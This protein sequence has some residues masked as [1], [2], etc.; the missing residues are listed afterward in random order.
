M[1]E[2]I[3]SLRGLRKDFPIERGLLRRVTGHI[4]AVDGVDLDVG[5]G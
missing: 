5:Q 4:R 3:L 2:P 1:H